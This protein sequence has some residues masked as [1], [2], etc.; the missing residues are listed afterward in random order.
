M[1][2]RKELAGEV[3]WEILPSMQNRHDFDDGGSHSIDDAVRPLDEFASV[4]AA[5]LGHLATGLGKLLCL[6]K[7]ADDALDDLVG[8]HRGRETDILGDRA[9]L[10]RGLLRPAERERH[11]ARRIRLRMR[12]MASSCE[13]VRPASDSAMPISIAWRT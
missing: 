4:H 10:I 7:P 2:A 6:S 13:T 11:D 3:G 12:A 9:K 1:A 5:S 8:V